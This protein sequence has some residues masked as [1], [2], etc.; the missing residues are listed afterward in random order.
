M[1]VKTQPAM[2][3][4]YFVVENG[5]EKLMSCNLWNFNVYFIDYGLGGRACQTGKPE[6]GT[7][8]VICG[9]FEIGVFR[10]N[11]SK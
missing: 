4:I 7:M 3:G 1:P 6:V 2:G 11:R 9:W 8:L 10:E 5:D